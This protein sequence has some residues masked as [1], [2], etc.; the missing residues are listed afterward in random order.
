M[1]IYIYIYVC[2]CDRPRKWHGGV[3]GKDRRPDRTTP[4]GWFGGSCY[5][6][7]GFVWKWG[8]PK[9]LLSYH[10]FHIDS[11]WFIKIS[12]WTSVKCWWYSAPFCKPVFWDCL[13]VYLG[14]LKKEAAGTM[15]GRRIW[16]SCNWF[17]EKCVQQ[18]IQELMIIHQDGCIYGIPS[19]ADAAGLNWRG[20]CMEFLQVSK[21]K[22]RLFQ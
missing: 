21:V 6:L 11:Y 18:N 22:A 2:V 12:T 1:H 8:S 16:R 20:C 13:W 5:P 17:A 15:E 9:F 7:P 14:I 4:G 3:V 10:D 19:H